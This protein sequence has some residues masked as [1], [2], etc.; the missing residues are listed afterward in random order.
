MFAVNAYEM[1]ENGQYGLPYFNG[2]IDSRQTK[3]LLLTWIHLGFIKVFGFNELAIRLPSAI[4]AGTTIVALFYFLRKNGNAILSWIGAIILLT[5]L[6]FVTFH[7]GRTGDSDALLT[8]FTTLSCLHFINW[9]LKEQGKYLIYTAVFIGLGIMTKSFAAII[10]ILP[11]TLLAFWFKRKA[12]LALFKAKEIYFA[13]GILLLSAFIAFGLREIA[14]P[15]FIQRTFYKD[16]GRLFDTVENHAQSW[17]FYINHIFY[18]RFDF[19][20]P[21]FFLGAAL[22]FIYP[23][24]NQNLT[25]IFQSAFIIFA[26]YLLVITLSSTKLIWYDMPLYPLMAIVAATP[27]YILLEKLALNLNYQVIA[28]LVFALIPL[29]KAFFNAQ[30]NTMN[31]ANKKVEALGIYLHAKS[32]QNKY[33]SFTIWH[34]GYLGTLLCYKYMYDAAGANITIKYTNDFSKGEKVLV[35]DEK[36]KLKL[37]STHVVDTLEYNKNVLL[38]QIK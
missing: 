36:L 4:A 30:S 6:G 32:K 15:G 34:Q 19:W 14:E 29:R 38:T 1:Q 8:L 18:S 37:I 25:L 33:E 17:D 21:L 10:F 5:S 23:F 31:E 13:I 35:A 20:T 9:L 27:I 11:F 12:T 2:E 24:P 28:I 22:A 16:A 7:T 3:P 26:A